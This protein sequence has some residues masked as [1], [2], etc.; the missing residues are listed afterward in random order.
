MLMAYFGCTKAIID[1]GGETIPP[2]QMVKFKPDVQNIMFNHCVTCHGG[3]AP[4]AGV[5][6]TNYQNVRF[7][8]EDGKLLQRIE[9]AANPM[10]PSG[11][12]PSAQRQLIAKWAEDGFP[13]N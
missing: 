5:D 7:Y 10:P 11:L 9:S 3:T 13:E 1:E 12:L 8:T 2:D 6:L 4:S